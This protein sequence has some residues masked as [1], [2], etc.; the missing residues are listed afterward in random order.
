MV[1]WPMAQLSDKLDDVTK[2]FFEMW[3]EWRHQQGWR[4][5]PDIPSSLLSPH[6]VDNWDQ[7]SETGRTWFRQH[8]A[9]VFAAIEH[10]NR[11]AS[12]GPE[13]E[14]HK[15]PVVKVKKSGRKLLPLNLG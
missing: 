14:P 4:L 12:S 5:G 10:V 13:E 3:R 9:L 8:A 6:L 15:K 1:E 2:V 7:L 11:A